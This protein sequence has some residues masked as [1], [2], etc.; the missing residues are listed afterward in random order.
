[1]AEQRLIRVADDLA[2]MLVSMASGRKS[3]GSKL[4]VADVFERYRDAV[5]KDYVEHLKAELAAAEA[6]S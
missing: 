2:G 6:K 3:D 4:T 1:M 5:T